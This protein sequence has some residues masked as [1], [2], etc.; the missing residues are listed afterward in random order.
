[1][2]EQEK[3]PRRDFDP[4]LGDSNMVDPTPG[5]VP[6]VVVLGLAVVLIFVF[7]LAAVFLP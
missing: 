4:V 7:A 3:K 6:F 1:M 2:D 5:W